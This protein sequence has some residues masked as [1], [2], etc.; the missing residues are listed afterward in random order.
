[1]FCHGDAGMMN[2]EG[3]THEAAL[4]GG[5]LLKVQ[6][7]E[8]RG[9]GRT[10]HSFAE[11]HPE[12][13]PL[14]EQWRDTN[15][16]KFNHAL[17]L[18][19]ETV[20]QLASGKGLACTSCHEA[21]VLGDFTRPVRFEKH[22]RSC[23]ELQ[24]DSETPELRLPHG[25]AEF[26]SAFLRTLPKQYAEIALRSG[27]NGADLQKEFAVKKLQRLQREVGS[28]EAL[29]ER[30]LL[31][32]STLGPSAEVGSVT[33]I[34]RAL[35]T[36]CAFCHDVKRGVA[37]Q[38]TKPI[39]TERWL[40]EASFKHEAHARV[41]CTKCHEAERSKETAQIILPSKNTCVS[42]HGPQGGV[43]NTCITCHSYHT[44]QN[45]EL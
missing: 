10:I 22:C 38:V 29:E 40:T 6:A 19:G 34:T 8:K 43:K 23:H 25:N 35:Y 7:R 28:G 37:I 33:G 20:R 31:S 9:G 2:Q 27:T 41:T 30:I 17:H 5:G 12:F 26:L 32:T 4:M 44:A 11:D 42:C 13:R 45:T 1:V 15:S 24:F 39:S 16:L 14:G 36:G 18:T 21:D 3:G